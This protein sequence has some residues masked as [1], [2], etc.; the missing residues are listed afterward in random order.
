MVRPLFLKMM[1]HLIKLL[2]SKKLKKMKKINSVFACM[3]IFTMAYTNNSN[4][5]GGKD[6]NLA[7]ASETRQAASVAVPENALSS[8]NVIDK[9]TVKQLKAQLKEAKI[10]SRVIS[11]VNNNF[12]DVSKLRIFMQDNEPV[13][14]RFTMHNKSARIQFDKKGN[15]IYSII[16]YQED[17]LPAAVKSLVRDS[18]KDFSITL[19]QELI[20]GGIT[21]YKV[22]LENCRSYKQILV[23]NDEMVVYKEFEK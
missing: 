7:N 4:A 21:C 12:K 22:F 2:K 19:V 5:Q 15:W 23:N 13:M 6:F 8:T 17:D 20:Q 3:V 14:A 18:Y 1:I 11:Y 9:P 16:D 10:N